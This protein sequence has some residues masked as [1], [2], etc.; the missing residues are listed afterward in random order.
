MIINVEDRAVI[1][2]QET[3][4]LRVSCERPLIHK[5]CKSH[6][7]YL[8]ALQILV[9]DS[10]RRPHGRLLLLALILFYPIII[11]LM[12]ITFKILCLK[13]MKTLSIESISSYFFPVLPWKYAK[14]KQKSSFSYLGFLASKPILV[15]DCDWSGP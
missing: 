5:M 11:N 1:Y 10:L 2:L 14:Q 7:V 9:S 8:H 3:L 6:A 12:T 15:F 13:N 4:V